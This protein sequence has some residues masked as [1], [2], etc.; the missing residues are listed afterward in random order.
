MTAATRSSRLNVVDDVIRS[1]MERLAIPGLAVGLLEGGQIEAQGYG[2]ASLRTQQPVTA[3]MLFQIGSITKSFTATLVMQLVDEGLLD[4]DKPVVQ[5]VP[6][7]R[8]Q[9]AEALRLV[10]PRQLLSHTCGFFGDRFSD[11]GLGDDALEKS[12]ATFDELEQ[13][14]PPG[15]LFSYANTG[16]QLLGRI[17]EKLRGEVYEKAVLERLFKPLRMRSSFFFAHD[18]IVHPVS[19]GH[20]PPEP[21][22]VVD[23][24][25][26]YALVR[27]MHSAGAIIAP[28]G[29]MLRYAAFHMGDGTT[30]AVDRLL[31]PA[32][33]GAD[34]AGAGTGSRV[35]SAAS[36]AQMQT[37][38]VETGVRGV[39]YGLGWMI[40]EVD[41]TK[42]VSHGG[43]T[44]GFRAHLLMAPARGAAIA[45]LTN[46]SGGVTAWPAVRKA[47]LSE[48][49]GLRV[50]E[51]ALVALS[52]A[53][54]QEH[55]GEY[56]RP[57]SRVTVSVEGDGLTLTVEQTRVTDG[58][59]IVIPPVGA[60]PLGEGRFRLTSG[61]NAGGEIQFL[62]SRDGRRLLRLGLRLV[63]RT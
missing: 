3:D 11:H 19:V 58:K 62:A 38:Q 4:L 18:A 63:V 53:E 14:L 22:D 42:L 29:D 21:G 34:D 28:V 31:A 51:P 10:T 39:S 27:A 54:L 24:A 7:L 33:D 13:Q 57:N 9:D 2:M 52:Q 48:V 1:E 45:W 35:L 41:G 30:A 47:W 32:G 12:I 20:M 56:T 46:S 49:L 50:T 5:Y 60:V 26:P 25:K 37:P 61:E 40:E 55:A 8:L 44:N 43:S 59:H 36:L 23:V 17:V 16:Y 15:E 6:E